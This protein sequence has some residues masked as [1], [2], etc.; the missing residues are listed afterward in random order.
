MPQPA[1]PVMA[2]PALQQV[3]QD[4]L[5]RTQAEA[6]VVSLVLVPL[7]LAA[8]VVAVQVLSKKEHQLAEQRIQAEAAERLEQKQHLQ[9]FKQATAA[10]ES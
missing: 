4:H 1:Q 6:V 2:E 5:S 10:L 8:L 9:Q 3:F 7:A